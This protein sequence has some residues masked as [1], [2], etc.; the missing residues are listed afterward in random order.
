MGYPALHR[1]R[2]NRQ[3]SP[4]PYTEVLPEPVDA[5]QHFFSSTEHYFALPAFLSGEIPGLV[6]PI[7]QKETKQ[8]KPRDIETTGEA[9]ADFL[10]KRPHA[11]G[12]GRP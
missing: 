9:R 7:I 12:N 11:R 8:N 4:L 2:W 10:A 5:I 6:P 1:H 3:S